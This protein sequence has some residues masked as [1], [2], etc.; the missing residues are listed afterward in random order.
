MDNPQGPEPIIA[1]FVIYSQIKIDYLLKNK[2]LKEKSC[3]I[4]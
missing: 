2:V 1:T 4:F 3:F